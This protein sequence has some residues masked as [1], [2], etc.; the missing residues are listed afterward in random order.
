MA[1]WFEG[2]FGADYGPAAMW[3]ALSIAALVLLLFVYW[4]VRRTMTGTFVAGGRNRRPRLAILDAAAIDSRRR[5]VLLRRDDTEH[6]ILIGGP[7]DVVIEQGIHPESETVQP[8]AIPEKPT[9]VASAAQAP[10]AEPQRA[11]PVAREPAAPPVNTGAEPV[12]KP[13]PIETPPTPVAERPAAERLQRG[14]TDTSAAVHTPVPAR[15]EVATAQV[16]R[17]AAPPPQAPDHAEKVAQPGRFTSANLAAAA[18]KNTEAVVET[19]NPDAVAAKPDSRGDLDTAL[20][21]EL[22][23]TLD[24]AETESAPAA[25][26][27]DIDEN[28]ARMIAGLE[29]ERA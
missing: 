7:T 13:A 23:S 26:P 8:A 29:K 16:E 21:H 22:E 2:T 18:G 5:I 6:L 9:K 19:A 27:N 12:R 4:I 17:V 20:L 24:R 28:M 3:T 10:T 25:K 1:S 11:E 14:P 15:P